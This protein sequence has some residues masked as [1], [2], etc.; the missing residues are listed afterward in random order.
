MLK[1]ALQV[2]VDAI[3]TLLDQQDALPEESVSQPI[4]ER[5]LKMI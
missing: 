3:Q 4:K 2:Q 5:R 1:K